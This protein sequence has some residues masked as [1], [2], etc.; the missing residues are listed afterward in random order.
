MREHEG[1]SKEQGTLEGG[2][3][4]ALL[5]FLNDEDLSDYIDRNMVSL[6]LIIIGG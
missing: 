1:K 6:L 3:V 2:A 4:T 5:L